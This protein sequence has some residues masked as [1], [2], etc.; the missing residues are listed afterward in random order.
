MANAIVSGA[1]ANKP[2]NGGSAWTRLS[3]VRGLEQLGFTVYFVEQAA[4]TQ[5]PSFFNSVMQRF[6]LADK[7]ALLDAEG[8][9]LAGLNPAELMEVAST[10]DLLFN[11]GGH[12]AWEP[13]KQA[14]RVR[15]YYDD[16]PGY[17]QLWQNGARLAG[18]D[19]YFTLGE[20]IGTAACDIPTGDIAWRHTRPPVVLEDWA[21]CSNG[22][23]DRF[24]TVASWRGAYG[25]IE[26][27]GKRYGLKAHEFR[28]FITLPEQAP[29]KFEI[30]LDIHPGDQKDRDALEKHG[31]GIADPR[32]AA[33]TPDA[34]RDYVQHSAAE[35][36]A[37]QGIYVETNSGWFS[38]RT[39][40]YLASGKPA[41]VQHTGF[42]VPVGEG[43]L[44]FR[45]LKEALAG[46]NEIARD[47]SR[48]ARAARQQAEEVFD[49]RKVT[50]SLLEHVDL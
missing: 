16:D 11:I 18:H 32:Q 42:G 21:V 35:F 22:V 17:T 25:P 38:D 5:D 15:I 39:T 6:C 28:K 27:G 13:L 40:R 34:F 23:Q 19:F 45:T 29:Q 30:A 3:W 9:T 2:L 4:S 41:L 26:Y 8:A 12:L 50:A 20:N 33:G 37:A 14:P 43:L 47:Y 7:S 46:A 48:H 36:S 10:A 44:A 1:L 49:A 24:T 31:W